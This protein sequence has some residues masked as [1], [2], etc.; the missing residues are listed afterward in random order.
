MSDKIEDISKDAAK[1]IKKAQ[2]DKIRRQNRSQE[3]IDIDLER[4]RQWR[5]KKTEASKEIESTRVKKAAVNFRLT[6]SQQDKDSK[7]QR[8]RDLRA[9][10]SPEEKETEAQRQSIKQEAVRASMSPEEKETEAQR[11]RDFSSNMT[12]EKRTQDL[13]K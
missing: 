3:A 4:Q 5:A 10:M 9:S 2:D 7:A 6:V 13:N 11:L 12:E 1:K 8:L